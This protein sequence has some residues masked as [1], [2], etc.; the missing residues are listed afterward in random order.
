MV[1]IVKLRMKFDLSATLGD[2]LY[3][4]L[5]QEVVQNDELAVVSDNFR[6]A[7][8]RLRQVLTP[9]EVKIKTRWELGYYINDEDKQK[10][11]NLL[12]VEKTPAMEHIHA[13]T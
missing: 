13:D 2:I 7:M 12:E 4:L 5:T 9:L 8:Y 6:G 11:I 1:D 3:L 10:L